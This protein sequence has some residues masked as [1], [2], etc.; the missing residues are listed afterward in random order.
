MSLKRQADDEGGPLAFLALQG[1]APDVHGGPTGQ[2]T[3]G[4]NARAQFFASRGYAYLEGRWDEAVEAYGLTPG[5][6]ASLINQNSASNTFVGQAGGDERQGV[7]QPQAARGHADRLNETLIAG[8]EAEPPEPDADADY[9]AEIIFDLGDVSPHVSGPDTVAV[10]RPATE[11]AQEKIKV[12]KEHFKIRVM[13]PEQTKSE[14]IEILK[15][16]KP[17]E[18]H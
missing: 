8:W 6:I 16:H 10:M 13:V 3:A 2:S 12:D 17:A 18:L 9:A 11:I 7:G 5:R 4:Y 15:R 14:I 1:D